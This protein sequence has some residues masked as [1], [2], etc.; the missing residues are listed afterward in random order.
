MYTPVWNVI[1]SILRSQNHFHSTEIHLGSQ[2]WQ[3]YISNGCVHPL[4]K[5]DLYNDEFIKGYKS[6]TS[7]NHTINF[8]VNELVCEWNESAKSKLELG[9]FENQTKF[10]H[11][12]M[13]RSFNAKFWFSLPSVWFSL[14]WTT[15]T[16][17]DSGTLK[18]LVR[19]C[20]PWKWL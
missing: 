10:N 8:W 17:S 13:V 16:T 7:Q 5:W 1:L 20:S 15:V 19:R 9:T 11:W 12:I 4:F 3:D 18:I 14:T 6:T 2:N